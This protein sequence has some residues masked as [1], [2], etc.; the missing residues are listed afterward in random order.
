MNETGLIYQENSLELGSETAM[1]RDLLCILPS[2]NN[3][4][5]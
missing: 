5:L 1:G 3:A 2:L 4:A